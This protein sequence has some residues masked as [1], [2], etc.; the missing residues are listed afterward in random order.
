M[1]TTKVRNTPLM[2]P[3]INHW[4]TDTSLSSSNTQTSVG[5]Q[6][7]GPRAAKHSEVHSSQVNQYLLHLSC[8]LCP[9]PCVFGSSSWCWGWGGLLRDI[10]NLAWRSIQQRCLEKNHKNEVRPPPYHLHSL[11]HWVSESEAV[12]FFCSNSLAGAHCMNLSVAQPVCASIPAAER[13]LSLAQG[14]FIAAQNP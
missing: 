3:V 9:Q 6:G 14:N 8:F 5:K 7:M 11:Q 4:A 2:A 1:G 12:S 10:H 13:G